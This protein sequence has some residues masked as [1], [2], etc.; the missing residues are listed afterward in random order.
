VS[1]GLSANT[2]EEPVKGSAQ[3]SENTISKRVWIRASAEVV[4]KALTEARE[5]VHWFCDQALCDAREGGEL[6][7]RWRTGKTSQKGRARFTRI[8]PG[9][10][11]ELLW[12]D[13]GRGTPETVSSHTLSYEI[14]SKSGMTELAM[15]DKDDAASNDEIY[16]VLDQGWNSVLIELKDYCERKE[17]SAKPQRRSKTNR[18]KTPAE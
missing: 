12:I 6:V 11:L 14:R 7:A 13:D 3:S 1:F 5:L 9:A 16:A 8:A 4:Y 18:R 2:S 17:R 15:I 10:S